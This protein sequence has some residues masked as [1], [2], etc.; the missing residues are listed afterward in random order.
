MR[1]ECYDFEPGGGKLQ[2][3]T[4]ITSARPVARARSRGATIVVVVVVAHAVTRILQYVYKQRRRPYYHYYR[5]YYYY[6]N[7]VSVSLGR[8]SSGVQQVRFGSVVLAALLLLLLLHPRGGRHAIYMYTTRMYVCKYV[9]IQ[10]C[11][12]ICHTTTTK[13]AAVYMYVC[14]CVCVCVYKS[15]LTAPLRTNALLWRRRPVSVV[16]RR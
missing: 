16:Q 12:Y 11:K 9:Y 14:V 15:Q 6:Y 2:R 7:G 4:A 8:A 5:Y 1:Y 10:V 13:S 3:Q